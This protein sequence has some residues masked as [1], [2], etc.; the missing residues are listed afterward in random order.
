[1]SNT[2][3]TLPSA[4]T[5]PIVVEQ[6]NRGERASDI[7]SMLLR[8]RIIFLGTPI[9]DT[10]ANLVVAQL[11]FLAQD[12]AERDIQLYSNSTGGSVDAGLAIYDTMH[13]IQPQVATTVAESQRVW[14]HGSSREAPEANDRL[15]LTHAY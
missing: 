4:Y 3:L 13:L 7:Y 9:D 8:N 15:Y 6:T 2:S 5:V 1:M 14:R 10:V 11:L 12:D